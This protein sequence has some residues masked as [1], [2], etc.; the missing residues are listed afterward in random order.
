[1]YRVIENSPRMTDNEA[2]QAYSDDYILIQ[3]ES[4]NS[5]EQSGVVLYVGDDFSEL[6]ALQVDLPVAHGVVKE[7]RNISRRLSLGGL[8]VGA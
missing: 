2:R 5:L 8:V 4:I 6:F 1:M 7:G 3:R